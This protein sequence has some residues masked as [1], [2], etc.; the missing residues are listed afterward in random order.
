MKSSDFYALRNEGRRKFEES[1]ANYA[2][3]ALEKRN[4][5]DDFKQDPSKL[6]PNDTIQ[7]LVQLEASEKLKEH[8]SPNMLNFLQSEFDTRFFRENA[9]AI[10]GA[11]DREL[12]EKLED[13]PGFIEKL[14][15]YTK[16]VA[17][18]AFAS[19]TSPE[20]RQRLLEGRDEKEGQAAVLESNIE[21]CRNKIRYFAAQPDVES[22][23]GVV[24]ALVQIDF[25][26]K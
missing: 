25:S 2:A 16:E 24:G 7:L 6:D 3:N 9:A 22:F 18:K 8:F 23:N 13:R 12:A 5:W 1:S 4:A 20:E 21:Y 17:G 19:K 11:F 26:A 14:G 15:A 10:T